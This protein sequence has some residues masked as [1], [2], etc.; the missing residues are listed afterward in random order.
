[1]QLIENNYFGQVFITDT[2][3]DRVLKALQTTKLKYKIH[4]ID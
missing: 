1:M 4:E 2:D 3:K